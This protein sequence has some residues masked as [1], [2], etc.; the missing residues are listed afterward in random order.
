MIDF[1]LPELNIPSIL[2]YHKYM[3]SSIDILTQKEKKSS[4]KKKKVIVRFKRDNREPKGINFDLH[5]RV[6]QKSHP[7]I[8][9]FLTLAQGQVHQH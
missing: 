9:K 6:N 4:N 5:L 8:K 3:T 1:K 2:D 7:S